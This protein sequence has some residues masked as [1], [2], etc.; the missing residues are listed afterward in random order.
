MFSKRLTSRQLADWC[1]ALATSLRAGVPLLKVV[2]TQLPGEL[3]P[4]S[5]R[6]KRFLFI[7]EMENRCRRR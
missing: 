7:C 3:P 2:E 4:P 1:R 6:A 5:K